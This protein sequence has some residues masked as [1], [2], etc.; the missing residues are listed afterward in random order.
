MLAHAILSFLGFAFFLPLSALFVRW[1]RTFLP[2]WRRVHWLGIV[3]LASPCMFI[4]W[5][6]GPILVS[7]QGHHHVVNEHQVRGPVTLI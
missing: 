4:G 1:S 7:T 2:N 6:L 3:L 5:L